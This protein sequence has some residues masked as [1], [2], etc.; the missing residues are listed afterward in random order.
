MNDIEILEEILNR[1]IEDTEGTKIMKQAIENLIARNKELEKHLSFY[2]KNESYKAR[3][4]ELKEE[5]EW[6]HKEYD[7]MFDELNK[8]DNDYI[9][10]SKAKEKIEE[11]NNEKLNYSEDEYYLENEIKGYAIDKLQELLEQ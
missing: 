11:I 7:E 2:E 10:K 6:L 8:I 4:I 5:N 3:I 9:P 1:Q